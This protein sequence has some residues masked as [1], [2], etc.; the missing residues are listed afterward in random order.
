MLDIDPGPLHWL[1]PEQVADMCGVQPATVV[2]WDVP[3]VHFG[4]RVYFARPDVADLL[5]RRGQTP[6][7][8]SAAVP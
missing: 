5:R 2:G 4:W 6:V 8:P 3:R 7:W 1:T